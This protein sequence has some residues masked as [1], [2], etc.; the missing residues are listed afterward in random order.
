M[1]THNF[2]TN[3]EPSLQCLRILRMHLRKARSDSN[4]PEREAADSSIEAH[5]HILKASSIPKGDVFEATKLS[6][7]ARI[8]YK[9]KQSALVEL[10]VASVALTCVATHAANVE[11][12]L[13]DEGLELLLEMLTDGNKVVQAS[14]LKY[15]S[16]KIRLPYFR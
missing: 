13:A 5:F 14:C 4:E 6:E 12:N 7:K 1:K 2:D 16:V 3:A 11:G 15:I 8:A 10:G 9:K